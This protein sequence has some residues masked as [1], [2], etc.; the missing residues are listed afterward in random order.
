MKLPTALEPAR[1]V[2]ARVSR[3]HGMT[4]EARHGPA[5]QERISAGVALHGALE[6]QHEPQSFWLEWPVSDF[7]CL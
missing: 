2:S 4:E 6:K 1:A 5:A 3:L 7:F